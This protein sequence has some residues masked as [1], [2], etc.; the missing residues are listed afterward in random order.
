MALCP[1]NAGAAYL[2][3]LGK[4]SEERLEGSPPHGGNGVSQ[5]GPDPRNQDG[6][7]LLHAARAEG[8]SAQ[9]QD[10][11]GAK[12]Q[13]KPLGLIGVCPPALVHLRVGQQ[14]GQQGHD[15]VGGRREVI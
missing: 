7:R 8:A 5:E 4:Q 14:Q 11:R 2:I 10:A 9:L 12:E 6:Q 3:G 1:A 13:P 15:A